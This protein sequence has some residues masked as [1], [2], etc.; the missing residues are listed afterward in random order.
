MLKILIIED[1]DNL[2]A[3]L[4]DYF[5][6]R[7]T[8][9]T[10]LNA[11]DRAA[12]LGL[13]QDEGPD[14]L[15][16]DLGIPAQAG[17]PADERQG[18]SLA[19]WIK[20]HEPGVRVIVLSVSARHVPDLFG[21]VDSFFVKSF[22]TYAMAEPEWEKLAARVAGFIGHLACRSPAMQTLR[23][24]LLGLSD[25]DR[26]VVF[27]GEA[28]VGK[29]HCAR[30]LSQASRP[31]A[32]WV[33]RSCAAPDIE[34]FFHE[35]PALLAAEDI[36]TVLLQGIEELPLSVQAQL[37]GLLALHS[38]PARLVLTAS[39][40][41]ANLRQAGC[42]G[43]SLWR[44]L[45]PQV[46]GTARLLSVPPLRERTQDLRELARLFRTQA[47]EE[48]HQSQPPL[49]PD[50]LEALP[51]YHWPGNTAQFQRVLARVVAAAQG[52]EIRPEHLDVPWPV[53]HEAFW[54]AAAG[55]PAQQQGVSLR[56][57]L[58]FRDR[59]RFE[60]VVERLTVPGTSE[61]RWETRVDGEPVEIPHGRV[62]GLWV[63]L[64]QR[65][66]EGRRVT[67]ADKPLLFGG[68][69]REA[70]HRQLRP[71]VHE[72]RQAL[73]DAPLPPPHSRLSRF[74]TSFGNEEYGLTESVR[75]AFL[76]RMGS[77]AERAP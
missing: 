6:R 38:G 26:V 4:V 33:E 15:L 58:A 9:Y 40:S 41:P 12:A 3:F 75:F 29:R 52:K 74:I 11:A 20:Q 54:R 49:H 76:R 45:D 16:L 8:G 71:L 77:Q 34:S 59:E 25:H 24:A 14:L 36:G 50:C 48:S 69:P 68:D 42:L 13:I 31:G 66:G 72:L 47:A 39:D 30:L 21:L 28:G 27:Q 46:G 7:V 5:T 44:R 23:A 73:H 56:D 55:E 51:D 61:E 2:R 43:E 18:L 10:V 57:R 65:A 64:L 53:E 32:R 62:L 63:L 67:Q 19:R 22:G 70:R 17:A 1:D 37:A 60:L 35:L